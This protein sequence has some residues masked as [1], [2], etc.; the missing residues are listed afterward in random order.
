MNL[1]SREFPQLTQGDIYDIMT[2]STCD[3]IRW[4]LQQNY[5]TYY[6]YNQKDTL[7]DLMDGAMIRGAVYINV[8]DFNKQTDLLGKSAKSVIK[9]LDQNRKDQN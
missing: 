5:Y 6:T 4:I 1:I 2:T 9:H 3:S 8:P 7:V